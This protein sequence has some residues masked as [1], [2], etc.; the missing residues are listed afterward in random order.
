MSTILV[1]IVSALSIV[2]AAY[3][4]IAYAV[5]PLGAVLHPEVRPSFA[6][7]PAVVLYAHVFAAAVA[8]LVGPLQFSSRLRTRWPGAWYCYGPS[9]SRFSRRSYRQVNR[10]RTFPDRR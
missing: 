8:L 1:R 10:R 5:W 6:A 9:P 3:A 4:L 7:Q 2:V